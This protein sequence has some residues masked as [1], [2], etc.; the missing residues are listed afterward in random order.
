MERLLPPEL[1]LS[2]F[3]RSLDRWRAQGGLVLLYGDRPVLAYALQAIAS[4]LARG[5]HVVVHRLGQRL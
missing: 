4:L 2:Q 3:T 1:V 5:E